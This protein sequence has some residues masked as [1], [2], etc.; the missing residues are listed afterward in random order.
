MWHF[1]DHGMKLDDWYYI[2]AVHIISVVTSQGRI[3]E[4]LTGG[5]PGF[6]ENVK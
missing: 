6:P 2:L 4:F 3:Q 5:V 1:V